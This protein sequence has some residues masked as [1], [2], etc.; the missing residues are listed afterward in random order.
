MEAYEI[1]SRLTDYYL[2]L[3]IMGVAGMDDT[4]LECNQ[5]PKEER[6]KLWLH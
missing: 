5:Q 1:L 4:F 2:Y 6:E 3:H